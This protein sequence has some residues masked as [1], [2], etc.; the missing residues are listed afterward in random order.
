MIEGSTR[1]GVR[2]GLVILIVHRYPT[3]RRL[4]QNPPAVKSLLHIR[5]VPTHRSI[6]PPWRGIATPAFAAVGKYHAETSAT[7]DVFTGRVR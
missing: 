4:S 6:P 5:L 1:E 7:E 2:T 3:R